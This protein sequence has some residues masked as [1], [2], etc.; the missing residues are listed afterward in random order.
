MLRIIAI[1]VLAIGV[2]GTGYWGYKEHQEKDALLIQAENNY[3]RA[4]HDLAYRIDILHDKIGATLAMN[5][6][7]SLSPALADVWRI[8]SEAHSDVG[9]LPLALLPFNKTEEFLSNIGDFSYRTAVRDLEKE[10]LSN[11]EMK[12]LEKMYEQSADI[13]GELRKV[14]SLAIKNN[15]RWMD[16]E[17][18][19]ASGKKQADNTIIDGFKTVEKNV[20]AYAE[21]DF[22]PTFTSNK[23]REEGFNQLKGKMISKNEARKIAEKF[24]NQEVKDV[25][26]TENGEGA[27]FGF[28]SLAMTDKKDK[29]EINIDLTKKGGYP[30]YLVENREISDAKISLNDATNKAIEFL[31]KNNFKNLQLFESA[32]YDNTGTF[33]F[34]S[35]RDD[36]RIYPDTIRIK[37]ALDDGS[38]IGYSARDYLA[39]NKDRNISKPAMTLEKARKK[40]NPNLK[41]QEDRLAVITNELGDEVLCYEFLG[42]INNDT[43]RI[44]INADSGIEEKVEKLKNPEPIYNEI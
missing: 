22:G 9:Q 19:L 12:S 5:S 39:A 6:K 32:Q 25:K 13:Q 24:V 42:T 44:F 15:L 28:Y 11:K 38:I 43:Y 21:T 17:M 40:L 41:I 14:Q 33:S 7:E 3:Q 23:N 30:I 16:V 31:K 10:P 8:T 26:I 20:G 37:V 4:F 35:V 1:T 29:S 18:A 27:S 34:V 2:V 36:I